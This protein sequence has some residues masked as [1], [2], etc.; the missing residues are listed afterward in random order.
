MVLSL[1]SI[2]VRILKVLVVLIIVGLL[3]QFIS[4]RLEH[5]RYP[6]PGN[7]YNV[8]GQTL[9]LNCVG[10]EQDDEP[11]VIFESGMGN[12]SISWHKVVEQASKSHHICTYDRPG[13]GWSQASA[14]TQTFEQT[15]KNLHDLL[16]TA[17]VQPPYVMVGHS[18]GGIL[19]R[20]FAQA[21]PEKVVGMVLVDSST[22]NQM[23]L[24]SEEGVPEGTL[25]ALQMG[26]PLLAN[27][28]KVGLMRVYHNIKSVQVGGANDQHQKMALAC[29]NKAKHAKAMVDE[30]VLAMTI[31]NRVGQAQPLG[32]MPLHVLEKTLLVPEGASDHDIEHEQEWHELQVA[33]AKLSTRGVLIEAEMSDHNIMDNEPSLIVNAIDTVLHEHY[34]QRD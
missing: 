28:S 15:V 16:Q 13:L 2:A 30:V 18:I 24:F 21:Y 26:R 7:F 10:S 8:N 20:D 3:Y 25:N 4:E 27:L 32:N 12:S 1:K 22:E 34:L 19:I 33:L 9:H 17:N 5:A 14:Q 11:T 31:T 23:Q 29:R 6:A